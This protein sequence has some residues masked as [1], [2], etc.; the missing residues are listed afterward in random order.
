MT[1]LDEKI[2]NQIRDYFNQMKEPVHILFF[3]TKEQCD[4]CAD[5]RQLV[6][7]VSALSDKLSVSVH[8]ILEEAELTKQYKADKTPGLVLT[9]KNGAEL[10]DYG[11]RYAG[12]P[13]GHEFSSFI[14]DLIL[15]SNRDSGLS[16][17]TRAF[18]KD[19]PKPV[20]LQVFVTPT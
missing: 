11:V 5:T 6:E 10:T 20:S 2:Q 15:L 14:N 16:L 4:T 9:A 1:L 12:I 7:E 18:L 17:Q 8:D 13:S 19:L 3:G